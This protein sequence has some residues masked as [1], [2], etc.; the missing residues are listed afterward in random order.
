MEKEKRDFILKKGVL[1]VG[2]PVAILMAVTTG[3]QVPGYLFKFQAFNVK[4]FLVCLAIF[5]P[6]FMAAGYVWGIFV[7]RITRKKL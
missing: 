2:L 3:F 6:I 4:T 1:G 7:Y 5:T